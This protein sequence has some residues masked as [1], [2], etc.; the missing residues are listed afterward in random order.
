MSSKLS[1]Y[2]K[3]GADRQARSVLPFIDENIESSFKDGNYQANVEVGRWENCR[4]QGYVISLRGQ[5]FSRQIN[6]AF[7]EHRN[8]DDIHAIKWEQTTLN[9]PTIDGLPSDHS[10]YND[11]YGTDYRVGYGA[12]LEMAQWVNGVL[13]DFWENSTIKE[14]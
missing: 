5:D 6:V 12:V 11:K 2:L 13:N 8:S 3:D 4:E 1:E 9:T 7:F 14:Q 10:F